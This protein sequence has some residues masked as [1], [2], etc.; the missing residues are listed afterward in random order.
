MIELSRQDARRIAVRAQLL[1]AYRPL[2]LVEVVDQLTLVQID[3][4]TAIVR[5]PDLVAWSRL[6]SSYDASDSRPRVASRV[7][8]CSTPRRAWRG[9]RANCSRSRRSSSG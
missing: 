9:A 8:S 3:P 1:D 7:T 4:T 2:S 5:S 6:G